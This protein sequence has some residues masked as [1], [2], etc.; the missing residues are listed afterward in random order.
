MKIIIIGCPGA[1]KSML[2][3]RIN[4]FLRYPVMHL[5]KVYHTGGKAHITREELTNKINTQFEK[6]AN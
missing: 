4:E 5:D 2:T 6:I 1:G 3:K